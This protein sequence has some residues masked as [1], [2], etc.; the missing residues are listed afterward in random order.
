[1]HNIGQ[2]RDNIFG[3]K[4][5]VPLYSAKVVL[6]HQREKSLWCN[7]FFAGLT[8]FTT[9]GDISDYYNL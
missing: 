1:M 2:P 3:R 8:R 7:S 6:P 5:V 4:P 9:W